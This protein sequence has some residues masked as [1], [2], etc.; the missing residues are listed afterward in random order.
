M[1]T[2]DVTAAMSLMRSRP[3]NQHYLPAIWQAASNHGV[4]L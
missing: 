3:Q 4:R 2:E 1:A